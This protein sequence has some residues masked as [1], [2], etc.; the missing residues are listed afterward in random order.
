MKVFAKKLTAFKYLKPN[1]LL[2]NNNI[3]KYFILNNYQE[4]SDL[5]TKTSNP[6]FYEF[7]HDSKYVHLFLDIEIYKDKHPD[8][9]I[10]SNT[11][12]ANIISFIVILFHFFIC[13]RCSAIVNIFACVY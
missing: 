7:I 9:F 5:I 8:D 2:C 13:V 6:C 4:F 11:I 12:I 1:Q 3:K 10:N